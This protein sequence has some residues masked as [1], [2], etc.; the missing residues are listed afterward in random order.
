MHEQIPRIV[1]T[2]LAYLNYAAGYRARDGIASSP[3]EKS[4]R[5]CRRLIGAPV[6]HAD[7]LSAQPPPADL[8]EK[9][10]LPERLQRGL[11]GFFFVPGDDADR[12]TNGCVIAAV[13][14]ARRDHQASHRAVKQPPFT[15]GEALM[16]LRSS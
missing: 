10:L 12:D 2:A 16:H 15:V 6:G 3:L 13:R 1:F 11:N 8:A 14:S 5:H 7:N 9:A 4:P